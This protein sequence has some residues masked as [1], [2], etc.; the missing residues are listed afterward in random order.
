M[1]YSYQE[2]LIMLMMLMLLISFLLLL[3]QTPLDGSYQPR[4]PA[5]NETPYYQPETPAPLSVRPE[6][7]APLSVAPPSVRTE[8]D[9][10]AELD[11]V[12]VRYP[13]Y[14]ALLI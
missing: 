2:L 5:P 10:S 12:Q 3:L 13:V 6:T 8:Y 14:C 1:K 9:I 4:T 7:P 11:R